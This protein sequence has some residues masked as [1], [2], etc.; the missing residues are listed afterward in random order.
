MVA[1][2]RWTDASR[3]KACA[4]TTVHQTPYCLLRESRD[5]MATIQLGILKPPTWNIVIASIRRDRV[6]RSLQRDT[7]GWQSPGMAHTTR[8]SH[9]SKRILCFQVVRHHH[10]ITALHRSQA[11]TSA[12]HGTRKMSPISNRL[13]LEGRLSLPSDLSLI[14]GRRLQAQ[15]RPRGGWYGSLVGDMRYFALPRRGCQRWSV[16]VIRYFATVCR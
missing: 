5:M 8:I 9:C 11:P 13:R 12:A 10:T 2:R 14:F 16:R 3:Q 4:G 15:N 1:R 6:D 7:F